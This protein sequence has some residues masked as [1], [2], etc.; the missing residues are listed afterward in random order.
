MPYARVRALIMIGV[1][2]RASPTPNDRASDRSGPFQS[3]SR[4]SETLVTGATFGTVSHFNTDARFISQ[5]DKAH[6]EMF[7]VGDPNQRF[8]P[9]LAQVMS[10]RIMNKIQ[11]HLDIIM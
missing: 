4:S 3:I 6:E 8:S 5:P 9:R 2:E 1:S 10:Q 7:I 11:Y